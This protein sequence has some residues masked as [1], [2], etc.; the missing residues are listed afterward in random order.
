MLSCNPGIGPNFSGVCALTRILCRGWV[1]KIETRFI[2]TGTYAKRFSK[3][4]RIQEIHV[5]TT[6]KHSLTT[7]LRCKHVITEVQRTIS[8]LEEVCSLIS[9]QTNSHP[10]LKHRGVVVTKAG[11]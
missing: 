8:P 11:E 6:S 7:W 5:M 9:V 10:F 4:N 2:S 1:P 3:R